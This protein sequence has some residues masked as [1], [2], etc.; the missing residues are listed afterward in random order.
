MPTVEIVPYR[1]GWPQEFR[2]IAAVLRS[3]LGGLAVRIDHIGSTSVPELAAKDII[4]VQ[5]SVAAL[6]TDLEQA[7][8]AIGYVRHEGQWCDHVPPGCPN[9]PE[10]WEKW[11]M[12]A[13]ATVRSTNTHVRICGRM[14]QQYALLFRDFLRENPD[15]AEAYARLKRGLAEIAPDSATYADVK[16]PAVDLIWLAAK[17][18]ADA[19]NWSPNASD[20]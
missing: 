8:A 17:S 3:A 2:E 4:D 18:W 9:D 10:Q 12:R 6:S 20:G 16:D 1:D 11:L 19:T 5:V 14:N 13:P 7:F 15:T